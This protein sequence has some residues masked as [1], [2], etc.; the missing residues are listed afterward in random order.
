MLM[1]G[2][3]G[4]QERTDRNGSDVRSMRVPDVLVG[5]RV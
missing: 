2:D 4:L 3:T 1:L 5:I